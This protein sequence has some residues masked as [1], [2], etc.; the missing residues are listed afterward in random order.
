MLLLCMAFVFPANVIAQ[1]KVE[2]DVCADFVSGYIF[3]GQNLGGASIQPSLSLSYKGLSLNAWGS[4]GFD[5]DDDK[6]IDLSLNYDLGNFSVGITDYYVL[7]Y[8][9]DYFDFNADSTAHALEASIGY[10]FGFASLTWFT[11]FAGADGLDKD[12][13][14]AYSSYINVIVPF[15]LGGLEWMAEV[16]ATPWATDYY[17]NANGF[18]VCDISLSAAKEIKIND[19]YNILAFAKI[20]I[21]PT[22]DK[23]YMTFGLSL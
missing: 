20:T 11:M 13:N 2:A 14:R 23:A 3:R 5:K 7:G 4:A 17:E 6:E 10:D 12:G 22:T 8:D 21:N 19:S 9:N 18:A 15:A 16:G 1:D